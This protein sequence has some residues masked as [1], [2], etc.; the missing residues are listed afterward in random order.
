MSELLGSFGDNEL[1]PECLDG[2]QRLLK[3]DGISIPSSYVYFYFEVLRERCP[4]RDWI[5]SKISIDIWIS[6]GETVQISYLSA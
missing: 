1:S 2:A 5:C 4:P 6:C 3:D